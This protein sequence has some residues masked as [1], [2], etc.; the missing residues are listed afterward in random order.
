MGDCECVVVTAMAE[1]VSEGKTLASDQCG[2]G[3]RQGSM[4]KADTGRTRVKH[5]WSRV[6]TKIEGDM[7]LKQGNVTTFGATSRRSRE[8]QF[9]TSRR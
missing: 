4:W 2:R 8:G 1:R 7:G 5:K 9:P 6:K 3:L